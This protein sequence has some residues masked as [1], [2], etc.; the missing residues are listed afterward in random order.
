MNQL[1]RTDMRAHQ[2]KWAWDTYNSLVNG[3]KVSPDLETFAC[4]WHISKKTADPILNVDRNR[5]GFPSC[6]VLFAEMMKHSSSLRTKQE[7]FPQDL[8]EEIILT[9]GLMDDQAGTAVA[10]RALQQRFD[11]YPAVGTARSIV[12]Q[13]ARVGHKNAAGFRSRRLNLNRE[14]KERVAQV[15]KV[16]ASFKT[17]RV[18]ALAQEGVKFEELEGRALFEESLQL[19]SDL[20]RYVAQMRLDGGAAVVSGVSELSQRAAEE[21]GVPDCVPW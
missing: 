3:Q 5:L 4:L 12:L 10:L 2:R 20:L 11:V 8:Y 6:R 9:F 1:L 13:L 14:M 19:L 16:L 15:S 21:M 7:H 17:R 18:E